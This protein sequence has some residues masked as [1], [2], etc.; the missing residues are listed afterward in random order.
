MT[1]ASSVFNQ[2]WKNWYGLSMS[3]ASHTAPPSD[4]PN[5]VPSDLVISGVVRTCTPVPSAFL[6]RSTPAI[7]LPHWSFPPVCRVH[8]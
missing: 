2:N 7:R 6:I 8:P 5:F 1:S 4:F 3:G